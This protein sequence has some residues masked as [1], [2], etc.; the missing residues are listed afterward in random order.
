[1]ETFCEWWNSLDPKVQI[2]FLGV[3]ATIILGALKRWLPQVAASEGRVKQFLLALIVAIET[4][5][6]THDLLTAILAF[7]A[8]LGTYEVYKQQIAKWWTAAD[9]ANGA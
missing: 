7:L 5:V 9:K 6:T 4:W 2:M 3:A 8:A 1:M